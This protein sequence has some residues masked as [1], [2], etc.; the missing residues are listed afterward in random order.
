[1]KPVRA[2][3]C[4]STSSLYTLSQPTSPA[5]WYMRQCAHQHCLLEAHNLLTLQ[6]HISLSLEFKEADFKGVNAGHQSDQEGR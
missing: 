4:S 2:A 5:G 1:M 6:D 3:R